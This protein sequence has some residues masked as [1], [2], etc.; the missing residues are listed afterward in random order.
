MRGIPI[1]DWDRMRYEFMNAGQV[2]TR[3]PYCNLKGHELD[4]FGSLRA[5]PKWKALQLLLP[6][7][8]APSDGGECPM[9]RNWVENQHVKASDLEEL[10]TTPGDLWTGLRWR[11]L[12]SFQK[13]GWKRLYHFAGKFC[14]HTLK[15]LNAGCHISNPRAFTEKVH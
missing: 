2:L 14:L 12:V 3:L 9:F 13:Y 8:T 4:S 15:T 1:E 6:V 10:L 7:T 11:P 5:W